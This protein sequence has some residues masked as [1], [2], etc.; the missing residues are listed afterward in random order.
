MYQKQTKIIA[1][2]IVCIMMFTYMATIGEVIAV[3]FESQ[4]AKTNHANIESDSYFMK[5]NQ[6][7]HS[8]K[9]VVGEEN[10]LY[11]SIKVK[12]AGYLKNIVVEAV[13]A[14]FQIAEKIEDD[15]IEKVEG[16]KLFFNQIKNGN[17]VEIAIP[18][19]ILQKEAI[20]PEELSKEAKV[21]LTAT[22]VDGKGEEK[23]IEKEITV[24]LAWTAEKQAELTMQIAKYIPYDVNHQKGLVLQTI[25]K[26]YLQNNILPVKENQIEIS[27]PT[28]NGIKPE[29]VKVTTNTTKATKEG[30]EVVST[31]NKETNKL[32]INVKNE[33]DEQGII[34]WQKNAEDEF[35][36]TYQYAEEA[37]NSITAEGTKIVIEASSELT[38]CEE[39]ETKVTKDFAGEATLKDP[40]SSLVEFT[41]KT[42]I[43]EVSKGQIYANKQADRKLETSYQE[44][45][46]AN[47]GLAELTDKII[48][49]RQADNFILEDST[50]ITAGNATYYKTLELDKENFD[51]M[52]GEEGSINVLQGTN[53]ISTIDSKTE[54]NEQGKI[55]VDLTSFNTSSLT[56]ET[57]KPQVEG[58]LDILLTKAVKGDISYSNTQMKAV[59]GME[60][61][62]EGTAINE[63]TNFVEQELSKQIALT[64]PTSQAELTISNGNLS[65][66]VTNEN[67]KL[68]AILK[69]DTEDCL[70]YK[71][72]TIQ[73]I[74]P[75]YI[76]HINVKNVELFFNNGDSKLEIQNVNVSKNE[77]G[78]NFIT[79][80]LKGTQTEYML[81]AVSKGVNIVVTADIQLNQFTP[82][83]Q[84]EI[85]MRYTN[86]NDQV[87]G[88]E[89]RIPINIVAPIGVITTTTLSNYA[90]EAEAITAISGEEKLATIPILS[91]ARNTEFGMTVINNYTNTIDEVSILGRIPSKGN[92]NIET[93]EAFGSTMDMLLTG[94]IE[95]NGVDASKVTIYYSENAE[96]T[97]ELNKAE[98]G[99][100]ETP[101]NLEQIKSYLIVLTDHTMN[102]G[103]R[104][105]FSYTAQIPENLQHNEV[106]KG[107]YVVYFNN[108]LETGDVQDKQV[109]TTVGVTTGRG[110]V[111]ETDLTTTVPKAE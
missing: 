43:E 93:Q 48:I 58:K 82:N 74:L 99:W 59:K 7:I 79:L 86:R 90:E 52:L 111:I 12:E 73:I 49:N 87:E 97:K 94:N 62:L 84:D 29:E 102:T 98:N 85:I 20:K 26:S 56:I 109:A 53:L 63:E 89:V 46:T 14:N 47:I 4:T 33:P 13:E 57:S 83:K 36:V 16:N 18:I 9:K 110:P 55:E 76:E 11:T 54:S 25:V 91:E 92:K 31:Y 70:L 60:L 15:R 37:L 8:D 19:Q 75:N 108:H 21:R 38:I 103:D 61:S 5:G 88:R 68:T 105:N 72:P 6:K 100:K 22:Y 3:N 30:A 28:I 106:A 101:S 42:N 65:T 45:I 51:K 41:I 77:A 2:I 66:V 81:E 104:V 35:V 23:A 17:T 39:T 27:V 107:H 69:T 50:K 32:I 95:V 1:S 34:A 44:T 40:I 10:N 71:D 96:A 64:E 78:T 67:V 24:S 80:E